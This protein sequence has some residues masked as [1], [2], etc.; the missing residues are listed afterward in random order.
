MLIYCQQA[1]EITLSQLRSTCP[2]VRDVHWGSKQA[3]LSEQVFWGS[4]WNL[5]TVYYKCALN[6]SE[7]LWFAELWIKPCHQ[8]SHGGRVGGAIASQVSLAHLG[9]LN[10]ETV[11][12]AYFLRC[13]EV[14][15]LV[16]YLTYKGFTLQHEVRS[17]MLTWIFHF[18]YS[19]N[20]F[21]EAK[22]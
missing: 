11:E 16:Q 9:F 20:T 8:R 13:D 7:M 19:K 21:V 15:E 2:P 1:C 12:W 10:S 5:S 18:L 4:G 6:L 22:S 17:E 14:T 3:S